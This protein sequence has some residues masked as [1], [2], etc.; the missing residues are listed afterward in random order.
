MNMREFGTLWSPMWITDEPTQPPRLF[1]ARLRIACI[2]REVFGAA[3]TRFK[4]W[5]VSRRRYGMVS[6]SRS[7]S[8]RDHRWNMSDD[9]G[10]EMGM[11][12]SSEE[13]KNTRTMQN[14][15]PE[16]KALHDV[17][18]LPRVVVR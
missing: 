15:A 8:A 17:D 14:F 18:I 4:P 2:M 3:C 9:P 16:R 12:H 13:W 11:K 10:K 7:C 6:E 5:P 1:C